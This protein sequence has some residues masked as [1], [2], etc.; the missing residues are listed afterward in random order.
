MAA[1]KTAERTAHIDL[2]LNVAYTVNLTGAGNTVEII[3]HHHGSNADIYYV[4]A[5]TEAGLPTLTAEMDDSYLVHQNERV[6]HGK[7]RGDC[8]VRLI[9]S[10]NISVSVQLRQ[11][12]C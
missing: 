11:N 9:S 1:D 8:W 3:G 2:T 4:V 12:N 5:G 6:L 10:E 7:P